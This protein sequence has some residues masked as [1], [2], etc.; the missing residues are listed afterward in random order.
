MSLVRCTKYY[1]ALETKKKISKSQT[2]I[3]ISLRCSH[4]QKCVLL[5]DRCFVCVRVCV[6]S[7]SLG[8]HLGITTP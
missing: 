8:D 4:K 5:N 3:E 7:R 1:C 2:G 6:R